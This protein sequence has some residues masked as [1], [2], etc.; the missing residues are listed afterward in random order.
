MVSQSLSQLVELLT[1]NPNEQQPKQ[2][3]QEATLLEETAVQHSSCY[4]FTGPSSPNSALFCELFEV[5]VHHRLLNEAWRCSLRSDHLLR[6]LQCI[7]LLSR[8]NKLRARFVSLGAVRVL[9]VI[10]RHEAAAHFAGSLSQFQVE[11]LTEIASIIKRLAGDEGGLLE[12]VRCSVHDTLTQ[13]LNS[14]DPAVLPLVLVAQIG[15]A[16]HRDHYLLV[17][18]ANSLDVLLRIVQQYDLP[19]KR[20]AADLLALL[21]RREGVVQELL[22]L[23]C[24]GRIVGQ[25][26]TGDGSLTQSLL[27]VVCYMAAD[28]A[29]L[30]EMYQVGIIPVLLTLVG[31]AVKDAAAD[32]TSNAIPGGSLRITELQL[33]CTALTRISEADEMAYQVRQC[34]GVTLVGKLLMA[35]PPPTAEGN[36]ADAEKAAREVASLKTYAFRTLRY[37]FSMER[38][39]KV[40]KRLFPPDLFA[41]FIDVGHYNTSLAAYTNLVQ[42]FEDLSSKQKAGVSA[43]LDDISADKDS[44]L[45]SIR[46]YVILEMLGK[47]AYG[48]VYKARRARGDLLVALK[49]IPLTDIGIFGAT[50]AERESGIA[51]MNKEV[52]IL[53][54]LSHPNIV[55]YYES[56]SEGS[57]L[58]ICME[59]VEGVSLLDHLNSLSGKGK[60][61]PEADIWQ[62]LIA[63]ALA[64]NYI[65]VTKK[66]VHRDLTPGNIVLGQGADGLRQ[67]KIAD[68]GLARSLTGS[69]C[70]QS[71]VGTM[72]YTCPE[73]IQQERYTEKADVWSLGCVLY[74]IIMLKPPFD[75]SNPLSVASR[76]VEGSYEPVRDPASGVQY[77]AQLKQLVRAMMTVDPDKRPS[78]EQVASL[79]VGQLMSQ[80]EKISVSE[81]RLSR[82]LETERAQRR[83]ESA[84]K[85][86]SARHGTPAQRHRPAQ[87]SAGDG[88]SAGPSSAA[89]GKRDAATPG[90]T[91]RRGQLTELNIDGYGGS[92]GGFGTGFAAAA[93]AAA[94]AAMAVAGSGASGS[95]RQPPLGRRVRTSDA[96]A[97]SYSVQ[98][99]S[100]TTTG[101]TTAT[102]ARLSSGAMTGGTASGMAGGTMRPPGSPSRLYGNP[103]FAGGAVG[104]VQQQAQQSEQ[105]TARQPAQHVHPQPQSVQMPPPPPSQQ[106]VA[107]RPA[108]GAAA[109]PASRRRSRRPRRRCPRATPC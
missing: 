105:Q 34:N 64:L 19:F 61:M 104:V 10:F 48:A 35:E 58:Y 55:Q 45:R 73:I 20:L 13:L 87:W 1:V 92:G 76:I 52:V 47:G 90:L 75:G 41:L 27:R 21:S 11:T 106:C 96:S 49:E 71:I 59:L 23:N 60:H 89:W 5:L 93:V 69:V 74:H 4:D 50:D 22:S 46:G 56:F 8:D 36:A 109:Q 72:P 103:M 85:T 68:F 63:T 18:N 40:F 81:Q 83:G 7:R 67:T 39:R 30:Q 25:L 62:V 108:A 16:A 54:S 80:L 31:A 15:F 101:A 38:N 53:S 97:D 3:A 32:P 98:Q 57:N 107:R 77:S 43:A 17:A 42:H 9:S 44:T 29:A 100:G 86:P 88:H 94:T 102:V 51:S 14:N 78:I 95:A 6:V 28:V 84:G 26:H 33:T 91:A 99:Q 2:A 65:H 12:L 70:A 66:I 79:I 24:L 37:L 82:A